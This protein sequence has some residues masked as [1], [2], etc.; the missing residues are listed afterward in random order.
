MATPHELRAQ[1]C[2]L[3]LISLTQHNDRHRNY[4]QYY[5][6]KPKVACTQLERLLLVISSRSV[7]KLVIFS[8]HYAM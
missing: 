3:I 5:Q 8:G 6:N 7:P 2:L 4:I 1:V